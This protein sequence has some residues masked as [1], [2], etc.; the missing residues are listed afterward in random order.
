MFK[1][2][3]F[4]DGKDLRISSCQQLFFCSSTFTK[5]AFILLSI[6]KICQTVQFPKLTISEYSMLRHVY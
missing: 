2:V 4:S 6:V 3:K 5:T 1:K